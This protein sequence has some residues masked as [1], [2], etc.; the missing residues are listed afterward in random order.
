EKGRETSDTDRSRKASRREPWFRGERLPKHP[1][2]LLS[3][4]ACAASP[5]HFELLRVPQRCVERKWAAILASQRTNDSTSCLDVV[6]HPWK[7]E[8][9]QRRSS[10]AFPSP[11]HL[12]VRVNYSRT[13]LHKHSNIRMSARRFLNAPFA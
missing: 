3:Q 11:C 5:R 10:A 9:R 4:Q 12:N 8:F 2:L 7:T 1:P 13:D 6:R